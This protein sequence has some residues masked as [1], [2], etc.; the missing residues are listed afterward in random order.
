MPHGLAGALRDRASEKEVQGGDEATHQ[1]H[2]NAGS[3]PGIQ[4][5]LQREKEHPCPVKDG[6]PVGILRTS[7]R[8]EGR[9]PQR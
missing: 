8:W 5:L 9:C 1:L 2:G 4:M 3:V 6:Q 7:T